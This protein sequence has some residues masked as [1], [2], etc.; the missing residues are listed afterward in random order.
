MKKNMYIK[1]QDSN[2][3]ENIKKY[4]RKIYTLTNDYVFKRVF[5][6]KGNERITKNFL[7]V[8]LKHKY[9]E[10]ELKTSVSLEADAITGKT[11]ILD[12]QAT[13]EG[14]T[15]VDIEM[16]VSKFKD[17]TDRMLLYWSKMY[18]NSLEK[19]RTYGKAKVTICIMIGDYE[20]EEFEEIN[21]FKTSWHIFEDENKE[22]MLTRKLQLV[23]IE[24]GKL[25]RLEAE[26]KLDLEDIELLKWCKFIKSPL[27][28]EESA[29]SEEMIEAKEEII[30]INSSEEERLIAEAREKDEMDR[31]SLRNDG[32]EEGKKEGKI[33][34]AKK[35]LEEKLSIELIKRITELSEEEI[36]KIKNEMG[37]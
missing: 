36:E 32:Y 15:Q 25:E 16:Q 7:E 10:I 29:M 11:G 1:T 2:E 8:I 37:L 17:A 35:M 9:N 12:V 33:E 18:A 24:L 23:I 14:D 21:N 28:M 31:A 26:G 6:K 22:Y 27:A 30:R 13:L 34:D 19:G 4:R 5:G 20:L 3:L